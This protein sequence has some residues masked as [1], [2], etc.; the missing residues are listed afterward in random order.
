MKLP[1]GQSNFNIVA[2]ESYYVDRT[3]YIERLE[4]QDNPYLFYLR[5]RK[6]GKSLFVSMLEHYYGQQHQADFQQNFGRFYISQNPTP[7]AGKYLVLKFDFSGIKTD[8]RKDL[9]QQFANKVRLGVLAFMSAYRS[10]FTAADRQA[11]QAQP[12]GN[13]AIGLLFEMVREK[14]PDSKLYILIDEYDHFANELIAFYL[15]DFKE[16]V[17]RNGFVR[18]FFEL[19]KIET[20]SGLVE[21]L[22]ATGVSPVTLDSLTSGFNIAAKLSEDLELHDMMGFTEAETMDMLSFAGVPEVDMPRIIR[23]LRDWYDGYRF[24]PD[25]PSRLYNPEMVIYFASNY[26]RYKAYPEELLDENIAS[27]YHK[28]QRMLQVGGPEIGL[29]T[30][31]G[32]MAQGWVRARLTRQFTFERPWL[33]DDQV[34]LLYYLGMLTVKE[35]MGAFW[36]FQVP[37]LAIK[38]LYYSFFLDQFRQRAD[39]KEELY[40]DLGNAVHVLSMDNELKPFL[41]VVERVLHRLSGRDVQRFDESHLHIIFAALLNSAQAWLVQSQPEL[42]RHFVDILCTRLPSI[43]VN[44]SFAFEV[45]YLKKKDAALLSAKAEEAKTQL[46]SYLQTEDLQRV[47][48]LAAYS[49]VFVGPEAKSVVRL[50]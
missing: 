43:P 34:S 2:A 29:S 48:Q 23:D 8:D 33:P 37:N 30:M 16:I 3:M 20:S 14:A 25:A 5:P 11:I 31:E 49:I 22:F 6:F 41:Q 38:G 32:V 10:F 47:D 40:L 9:E 50:R 24:N 13:A 28:L 21:R 26:K 1:Y 12:S 27:D 18:K 46:E 36:A 45:K 39:L 7:L 15:E 35:R 4:A 44:W 42:E 17:S 19:I